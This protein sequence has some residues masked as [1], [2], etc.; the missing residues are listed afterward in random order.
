MELPFSAA[1]ERNK[2][3]ILFQLQHHFKCAKNVLEL[4]SGTGQHAVYFAK[5]LPHLNWH[6]S[7][8]QVNHSG[9]NARINQ[10]KSKNLIP[11]IVIDFNLAWELPKNLLTQGIDAMFTANTF[12]IVSWPLVQLFFT[13]VNKHLINGGVLC[14]YG[15]FN[16]QGNYTSQGNADFDIWLK[17]RGESS[18]IR[19]FEAVVE[20]AESANLR[21]KADHEMP[22]NNRLLV[23]EKV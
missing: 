4:G 7:D 20:L 15:P 19:D 21:L 13:Q 11:P 6:C 2:D 14:V 8:L 3:A 18:A 16:Y 10:Q 9:I 23:F 1:C 22:A 17:E 5:R 12:H